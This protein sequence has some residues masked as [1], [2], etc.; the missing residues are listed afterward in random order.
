MCMHATQIK[1]NYRT[2]V[3]ALLVAYLEVGDSYSSYKSIFTSGT[4]EKNYRKY[5]TIEKRTAMFLLAN[6]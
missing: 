2:K 4:V 1:Y 3:Y 5:Q 6:I